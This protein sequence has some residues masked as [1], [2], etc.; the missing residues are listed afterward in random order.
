MTDKGTGSFFQGLK[1]MVE[2]R[3]AVRVSCP[4]ASVDILTGGK[5]VQPLSVED[6]STR[7][8]GVI[9]DSM[10]TA[11]DAVIRFKEPKILEGLE[12]TAQIRAVRKIEA[13]R[14]AHYFAGYEFNLS[15]GGTEKKLYRWLSTCMESSRSGSHGGGTRKIVQEAVR[16]GGRRPEPAL[17]SRQEELSQCARLLNDRIPHFGLKETR[18]FIALEGSHV[19][20]VLPLVHDSG[21]LLIPADEKSAAAL[22]PLRESGGIPAQVWAPAFSERWIASMNPRTA[23]L[24]K[25]DTL[26]SMFSL[27]LVYAIDFAKVTELLVDSPPH[28]EEFFKMWLFERMPE[29]EG[30]LMSLNLEMFDARAY[31]E[32]PELIS[33]MSKIRKRV[34]LATNLSTHFRPDPEFLKTWLPNCPKQ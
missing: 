3:R 34:E 24:Q 31:K 11:P 14:Q 9:L 21:S 5:S 32:R 15:Q 22:K 30:S 18:F 20:S 7:G 16:S 28:L 13:G 2:R 33:Y 4:R 26:F 6:L 8:I 17:V 27:T 25:L 10:P 12:V 29:S 23:P 1:N 19:V